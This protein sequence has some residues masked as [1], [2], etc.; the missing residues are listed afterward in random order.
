MRWNRADACL[1]GISLD[2]LTRRVPVPVQV[3]IRWLK[4]ARM[5]HR[6][7]TALAMPNVTEDPN[8]KVM[9]EKIDEDKSGALSTEEVLAYL[10]TECGCRAESALKFMR[11][12]DTNGD[13]MVSKSEWQEAWEHGEFALEPVSAKPGSFSVMKL[14]SKHLSGKHLL[15]PI[16][17][18][19]DPKGKGGRRKSVT[20]EKGANGRRKSVTGG[21]KVL[22]DVRSPRSGSE[23]SPPR[24]PIDVSSG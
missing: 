4:T 3:L 9:F 10:L 16:E 11:V 23:A 7:A 19:S 14:T 15:E 12:L 2:D 17:P 5:V 8:A 1:K 21:K 20:S 13:G 22:P 18:Q 6:I 24:P